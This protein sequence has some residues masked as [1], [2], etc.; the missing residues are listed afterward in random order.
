MEDDLFF[1]IS[2]EAQLAAKKAENKK[3]YGEA[4]ELFF[5]AAKTIYDYR[6]QLFATHLFLSSFINKIKDIRFL[7]QKV[8]EDYLGEYETILNKEKRFDLL[9]EGFRKII[10]TL[11]E[12]GRNEEIKN[13]YLKLNK[14]K[15]LLYLN[16]DNYFMYTLYLIWEYTS[17]Y[18]ESIIRL[19]TFIIIFSCIQTIF[20]LPSPYKFM[21]SIYVNIPDLP[22]NSFID[23]WYFS[24]SIIF[25]PIWFDIIPLNIF[26][27]IFILIRNLFSII[28]ITLFI[29]I[30]IRKLKHN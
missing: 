3:E 2:K 20:F 19:F 17:N 30:I 5:Q 16:S 4:A 18:G 8:N 21:E 23:Y 25:N 14:Y 22:F 10:K 1:R 27:I 9:V 24:I 11:S 28:V 26:G 29:D 12:V 6:N 15:K 7:K 13:Y